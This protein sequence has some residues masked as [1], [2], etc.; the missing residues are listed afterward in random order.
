MI[1]TAWRVEGNRYGDSISQINDERPRYCDLLKFN[2]T[3]R[4]VMTCS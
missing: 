4:E 1:S 3:Y 2:K